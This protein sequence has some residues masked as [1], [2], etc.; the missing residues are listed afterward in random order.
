MALLIAGCSAERVE[1]PTFDSTSTPV[2]PPSAP[3]KYPAEV[4]RSCQDIRQRVGADLPASEPDDDSPAGAQPAA[5]T[6]LFK[7]AEQTIT[8]AIKSWRSTDATGVVS[9]NDHAKSYFTDR[10]AGWDEEGAG[11]GS[12][13]RWREARDSACAMEALDE[14]AVLTVAQ[15]GVG[16]EQCRTSVRALAKKFYSAVQ[17]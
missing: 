3:V 5:K 9:G 2:S 13:A 7:A 6:C 15:T 4:L 16:G 1:T 12:I 10:T 17:P 11:I 14:N 8:F